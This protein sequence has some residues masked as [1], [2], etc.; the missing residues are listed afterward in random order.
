MIHSGQLD[1][2]TS[3]FAPAAPVD[4]REAQQDTS[5][6]RAG[7]VWRAVLWKV[8]GAPPD[9]LAEWVEPTRRAGQPSSQRSL[10]QGIVRSLL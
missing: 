3:D 8:G 4:R 10:P 2:R 1:G 9:R 6:G 7:T 5:G